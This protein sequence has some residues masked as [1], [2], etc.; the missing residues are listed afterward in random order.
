M[1]IKTNLQ[2]LKIN[3]PAIEKAKVKPWSNSIRLMFEVDKRTKDEFREVYSFLENEIP[4]GSFS[5]KQ[6]I[7]STS[8]LRDKFDKLL[9][10]ARKPNQNG[11]EEKQNNIYTM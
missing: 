1:L 3:S 6:N 9:I 4:K 2:E 10:E 5:W 8:T 7:L 11:K